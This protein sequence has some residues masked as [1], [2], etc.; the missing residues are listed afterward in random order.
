MKQTTEQLMS[1]AHEA[2]KRSGDPKE[3]VGAVLLTHTGVLIEAC[4]IF[5]PL[6]QETKERL[7]IPAKL[8][9]ME[10]AERAAI[11]YA[12]KC[13]LALK[14]G[15]IYSTKCPCA[16][17]ARSIAMTGIAHVYTYRERED[18]TWKADSDTGLIILKEAKVEVTFLE[19]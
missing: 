1:L 17:C 7:A 19:P 4:N 2:A 9:F 10:H 13:G 11:Y 8:S 18:S 6:V 5:P 3:K 16:E 12:A 14:G 15:S